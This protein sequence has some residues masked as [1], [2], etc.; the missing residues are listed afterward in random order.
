MCKTSWCNF[1]IGMNLVATR[2]PYYVKA[3][4]IHRHVYIIIPI[5]LSHHKSC[6]TVGGCNELIIWYLQG[7]DVVHWAAGHQLKDK[8]Q[9]QLMKNKTLKGLLKPKALEKRKT[10]HLQVRF[11]PTLTSANWA[12]H[13]ESTPCAHRAHR[14]LCALRAHTGQATPFDQ[15]C[16]FE[17]FSC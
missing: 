2:K 12:V 14:A 10:V 7:Q 15:I 16:V 9:N 4:Q 1:F 13:T 8:Q 5:N 6:P 3:H 17:C 11:C